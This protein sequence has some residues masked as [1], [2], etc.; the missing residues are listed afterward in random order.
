M[1]TIGI[2]VPD[3][4]LQSVLNA[5]FT[6]LGYKDEVENPAFQ[7]GNQNAPEFIPNSL[8]KEQ[9]LKDALIHY[10]KD[11][12][13]QGRRMK[14]DKGRKKEDKDSRKEVDQLDIT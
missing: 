2:T 12:M 9:V 14:L 11:L 5:V 13:R 4:K 3:N 8:D 1:A 6:A 7:Q 10:V